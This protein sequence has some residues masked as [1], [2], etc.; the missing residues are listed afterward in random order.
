[1]PAGQKILTCNKTLDIVLLIDGSATIGKKGFQSE[2]KAAGMLIDAFSEP[3]SKGNFAIILFSGPRTWSGVAQCTGKSAKKVDSEKVCGIKTVTH[4]TQ[5]LKKVK[6]LVAGLDY[7]KGGALTSLALF[8]AKAELN[9]GRKNAHS[10]VIVFS[11][12]RP[13]SYRKTEMASTMVRKSARLV[14]VPV[15]A[16][17]PLASIKKWATRRWQENVISVKSFKRLE[18]PE[19]VTHI[20]ANICPKK[21]PK[22]EMEMP[23][24]MP[25][26]G[27]GMEEMGGEMGGEG[28]SLD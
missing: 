13:L 23:M 19:V 27:E 28:M 7:P 3:G 5:D 2:L 11:A 6:Q 10:N 22:M 9:L 1:L 25:M 21:P 16:N 15:S 20:V 26:E 8:A 4:F 17:A 18:N 24:E 12:G 14:W